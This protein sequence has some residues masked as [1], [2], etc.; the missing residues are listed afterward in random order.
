MAYTP[1][2]LFLNGE[3]W[4]I[5]NIREKFNTHYFFENFNADPDNID[6][7]EY[8]S[9]DHGTQMMV[10]E[11]D[12]DHYNSMIDHIL[13]NDLDQPGVYD[14]LKELMNIDS[15]I[16]HL[17]TILYSANTS[18]GHNREWW[19]PRTYTGKWQWLIVDIDRGFNLVL[20]LIHI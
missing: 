17:V 14:Q 12:I 8:T 7:L 18:W 19:R 11:G 4:G 20:S 6:H 9:T 5:H 13:N 16:D 2:A 10:I 15:F 3:Y 1:S